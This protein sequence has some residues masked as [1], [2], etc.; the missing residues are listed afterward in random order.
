MTPLMVN[1]SPQFPE[2]PNTAKSD[3]YSNIQ[4]MRAILTNQTEVFAGDDVGDLDLNPA[5]MKVEIVRK[6]HYAGENISYGSPMDSVQHLPG[7]SKLPDLSRMK[8][9]FETLGGGLEVSLHTSQHT[10]PNAA[11]IAK[12]TK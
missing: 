2:S 11:S 3:E 7:V 9:R 6:H 12:L 4:G 5:G 8:A 1:S 10:Y